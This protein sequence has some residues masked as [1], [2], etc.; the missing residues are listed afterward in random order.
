MITSNVEFCYLPHLPFYRFIN[1]KHCK[2]YCLVGLDKIVSNL[3]L[4]S[5]VILMIL[6]IKWGSDNDK[7]IYDGKKRIKMIRIERCL[8]EW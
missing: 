3:V 7:T 4:N 1:H 6:T 2:T 5:Q 8:D